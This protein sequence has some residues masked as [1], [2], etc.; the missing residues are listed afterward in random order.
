MKC[1]AVFVK[2]IQ[3]VLSNNI[4]EKQASDRKDIKVYFGNKKSQFQKSSLHVYNG[5]FLK[6]TLLTYDSFR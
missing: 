3:N 2:R 5:V 4:N 1:Y 6:S